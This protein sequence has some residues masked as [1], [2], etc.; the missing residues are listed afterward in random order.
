MKLRYVAF[1]LPLILSSLSAG[2]FPGV[3]FGG[4]NLPQHETLMVAQDDTFGNDFLQIFFNNGVVSRHFEHD[5]AGCLSL[6]K[7]NTIFL[8]NEFLG[9]YA[10]QAIE[11]KDNLVYEFLCRNVKEILSEENLIVLS[12]MGTKKTNETL[13]RVVNAFFLAD[14]LNVGKVLHDS[15]V[16]KKQIAQ[17]ALKS[18]DSFLGSI[19]DDPTRVK[20]HQQGMYMAIKGFIAS[21]L[22]T[23]K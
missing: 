18:V 13:E 12:E 6:D 17:E 3:I 11:H 9:W 19:D 16:D 10:R 7:G 22:L 1:C 8:N 21:R 2:D 5:C 23:Y 14:M 15:N 4:S 20:Y